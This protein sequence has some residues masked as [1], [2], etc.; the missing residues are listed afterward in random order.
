VNDKYL[1][2]LAEKINDGSTYAM[3]AMLMPLPKP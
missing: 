3:R 2:K 1:K